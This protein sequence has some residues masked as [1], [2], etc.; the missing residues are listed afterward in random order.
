VVV[1]YE[2]VGGVKRLRRIDG[3]IEPLPG[4][5]EKKTHWGFWTSSVMMQSIRSLLRKNNW[6]CWNLHLLTHEY[7]IHL[8]TQKRLSTVRSIACCEKRKTALESDHCE[9]SE[10]YC[11]IED[12]LILKEL[13]SPFKYKLQMK[14]WKETVLRA[15]GSQM[16]LVT[17]KCK[18]E[19][20][21]K[22]YH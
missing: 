4:N 14:S 2:C 20:K 7:L 15:W 6:E 19:Q 11:T 18:G 5:L 12:F 13:Q 21:E 3:F 10:M 9:S 22:I 16:N 17:Y 1:M 8:K